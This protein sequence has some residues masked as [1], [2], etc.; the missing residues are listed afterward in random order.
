MQTNTHTSSHPATHLIGDGGRVCTHNL[1]LVTG[2][3]SLMGPERADT[4]SAIKQRQRN[5]LVIK[6]DGSHNNSMAKT[7]KTSANPVSEQLR[8]QHFRPTQCLDNF[9]A[10]TFGQPSVWTTPR[11]KPSASPVSGQLHGQHFWW[12][13][14]CLIDK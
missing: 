13:T 9:T 7:A 5:N 11:P 12:S 1:R 10:N 4:N 14:R 2:I 6:V 8:G 3:V